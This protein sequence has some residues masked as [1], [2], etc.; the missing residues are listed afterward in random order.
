MRLA[1]LASSTIFTLTI[2]APVLQKRFIE[3]TPWHLTKFFAFTAAP[4]PDGVSAISFHFCDTN[5]GIEIRPSAHARYRPGRAGARSIRTRTIRARTPLVGPAGLDI[6][7]A[8]G[9]ANTTLQTVESYAGT[10]A[11]SKSIDVPITA[12]IA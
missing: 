4:G 10:K 5:A 1:T 9:S 7:T 12:L 2:A 6:V 3:E 8:F 11:W